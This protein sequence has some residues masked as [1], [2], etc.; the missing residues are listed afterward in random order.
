MNENIKP[1]E[2]ITSDFEIRFLEENPTKSLRFDLNRLEH[3]HED[4]RK[5][6]HIHPGNDDLMIHASPMSPLE[7]LHLFLYDLKKPE[8]PGT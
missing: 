2:I 7:I 3:N 1:A 4:K 5:R 8:R 6:F